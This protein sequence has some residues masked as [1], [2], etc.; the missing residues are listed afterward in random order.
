MTNS[1]AP[2]IQP[3][4]NHL[5]LLILIILM[6]VILMVQMNQVI[7]ATDNL[8]NHPFMVT[9]AAQ[10]S[11]I[12][13]LEMQLWMNELLL[14]DDDPLDD[15]Q[16]IESMDHSHEQ[17]LKNF[18]IIKE[19]YLGDKKQI[20][21]IQWLSFR[22]RMTFQQTLDMIHRSENQK[23]MQQ[24][25][26]LNQHRTERLEIL[27][28]AVIQFADRKA[29]NFH[30]QAIENQYNVFII[31]GLLVFIIILVAGLIIRQQYQH[32][33]NLDQERQQ[34]L[35][36]T[37]ASL[38]AL[39]G[40]ES[41]LWDVIN[42][43]N[44]LISLK[45]NQGRFI[46]VNR[47]FEELFQITNAALR[48]RTDH[49]A[50][51]ATITTLWSAQEQHVAIHKERMD[52]EI[53]LPHHPE[54]LT[55]L[56]S[57]YPLLDA[58]GT[59]R[60]IAAIDLDISDR[61][62]IEDELR[63]TNH[64]LET[65]FQTTHLAIAIL[66]H[67][68]QFV[69]V[70]P[71]YADKGG[72]PV[73][74]YPGKN[75]FDLYPNH[76]NKKIFQHVVHTGQPFSIQAKPFSYPD[77]PE[78]GVTYWDWS[79]YPILD[80][81]Q[82]V[83][84]LIFVLL[85]V[86]ALK[87][88]EMDLKNTNIMLQTILDT[89][90]SRV[91]WKDRNLRF[92]GGNRAFTQHAGLDPSTEIKG[93]TDLDLPWADQAEQIRRED[94]ELLATAIPQGP[95]SEFYHLPDGSPCWISTTRMPLKSGDGTLIGLLGI[96]DDITP[97]KLAAEERVRLQ[98]QV[99][100]QDRLASL[101]F[102]AAGIAHEV[103]NPNNIIVLN[104]TL[105]QEIWRDAQKILDQYFHD[106]GDFS[107]GGTPY[108]ETHRS[109]A[110][111]LHGI[112]ENARRIHAIIHNLRTITG[113]K[114]SQ[115]MQRIDLREVIEQS[116]SFLQERIKRHTRFFTMHWDVHSYIIHGHREKLF[117]I[118]TNVILNALQALPDQHHEVEV[119]M[120]RIPHLQ[121]IQV[122]IH[123]QGCGMAPE[124][125]QRLGTPFF[126]TRQEQGGMGMGVTIA[127]RIMALHQGRF[128]VTSQLGQGT[129]V[130]LTF[131]KATET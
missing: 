62:K 79:L 2:L 71:A 70:N 119:R 31:S 47:R 21:Q 14:Q 59:L 8:Y 123:D 35:L 75:H 34:A 66:D 52:A 10:R 69:R 18:N 76:E 74:F 32:F 100:Q 58:T 85:D 6:G 12:A 80:D 45:D 102:L 33:Q 4:R 105:I 42:H 121:S 65:L 11:K 126:T 110:T 91:Y 111:L 5:L 127:Q 55:F 90:P 36:T 19:R 61:K 101:G 64:L 84:L 103:N 46:L 23:A 95:I 97:I 125:L 107:L 96:A 54:P 15:Q 86:T 16:I 122:Q 22:W 92:V 41:R 88:H 27:L 77:H 131:P 63:R 114:G 57:R 26:W 53:T 83:S 44:A 1:P 20:D 118:F 94:M 124:H 30:H 17:F 106:N 109:V 39:A 9:N 89:I 48:G 13:L 25:H 93:K 129:T 113:S 60:G 82:Q 50:I 81:Q 104:V 7:T 128:E 130:T 98:E 28:D 43:A 116:A 120:W 51:P 87:Q 73:D 3:L 67:Q 40:S 29:A 49:P 38:E 112:E 37:Q 56:A 68:F 72:H 115:E 78:W 117:Q 108:S 24:A 99:Y